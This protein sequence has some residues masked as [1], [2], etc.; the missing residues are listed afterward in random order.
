MERKQSKESFF[1]DLIIKINEI[2][3]SEDN[4]KIDWDVS[5]IFTPICEIR[6]DGKIRAMEIFMDTNLICKVKCI[7]KKNQFF[8]IKQIY[9]DCCTYIK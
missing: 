1:F 2:Y 8:L 3:S 6:F 4:I 5:L 7:Q 9:L